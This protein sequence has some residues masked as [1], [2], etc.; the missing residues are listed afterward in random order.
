MVILEV[1][2]RH[3]HNVSFLMVCVGAAHLDL[4]NDRVRLVP[5]V[6]LVLRTKCIPISV[7][8]LLV[9]EVI[10]RSNDLLLIMLRL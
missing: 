7:L 10:R 4:G 5:Q 6:V 3:F 1:R 8:L 9:K 2:L